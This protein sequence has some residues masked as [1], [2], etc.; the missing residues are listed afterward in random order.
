ML[1]T[2]I[3]TDMILHSLLADDILVDEVMITNTHRKKLHYYI[4]II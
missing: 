4:E 3:T 1:R 2:T